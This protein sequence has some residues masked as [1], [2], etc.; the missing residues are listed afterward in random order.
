MW[1]VE[2]KGERLWVKGFGLEVNRIVMVYCLLN[3]LFVIL[4]LLI[5]HSTLN[6][7]LH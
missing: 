1:N 3:I 5:N 6:I 4:D 7:F 2:K